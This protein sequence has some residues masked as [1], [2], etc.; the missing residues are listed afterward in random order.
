M[1]CRIQEWNC[2]LLDW[3]VHTVHWKLS[4]QFYSICKQLHHNALHYKTFKTTKLYQL[5]TQYLWWP[6]VLE[7]CRWTYYSLFRWDAK[8][9]CRMKSRWMKSRKVIPKISCPI[10]RTTSRVAFICTHHPKHTV[11]PTPTTPLVEV[12]LPQSL[13][14][15]FATHGHGDHGHDHHNIIF[16]LTIILLLLWLYKVFVMLEY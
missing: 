9:K 16:Y 2:S 3:G 7:W 15:S 11:F 12:P 8:M 5:I 10:Y 13:P 1:I 14:G 6:H 4:G